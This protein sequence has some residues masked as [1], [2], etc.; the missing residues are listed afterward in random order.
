MKVLPAVN[1]LS[2][3]SSHSKYAP[4]V[5]PKNLTSFPVSSAPTVTVLVNVFAPV[6]VC[7]PLRCA[8]SEA[9][10]AEATAVPCHVPAAI[11]P[12]SAIPAEKVVALATVIASELS[13]VTKCNV[14]FVCLFYD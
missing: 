4:D 12:E 6:K 10:Y 13:V 5:A 1:N 9:R 2:A 8:V 14:G 11:V 3:D 7:V